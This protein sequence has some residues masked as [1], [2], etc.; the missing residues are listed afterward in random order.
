[1]SA[2]LGPSLKKL[3]YDTGREL[4]R[5]LTSH[6]IPPHGI[7]DKNVARLLRLALAAGVDP[8]AM[9]RELFK[10]ERPGPCG[11]TSELIMQTG[12]LEVSVPLQEEII[13]WLI[14]KLQ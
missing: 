3:E 12:V 11:Y 8:V 14:Q 1:M 9:N 13:T 5:I 7:G 10:E 6:L 4:L 2:T